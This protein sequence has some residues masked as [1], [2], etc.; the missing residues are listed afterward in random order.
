MKQRSERRHDIAN[1]KERRAPSAHRDAKVSLSAGLSAKKA[2]G[3]HRG[4][5]SVRE[6]RTYRLTA[7]LACRSVG[8]TIGNGGLVTT[9]LTQ[10][11]SPPLK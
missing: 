9:S 6:K 4:L 3:L 1:H 8:R 10:R 11:A 5:R 7:I 2:P